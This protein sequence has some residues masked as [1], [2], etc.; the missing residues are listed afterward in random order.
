MSGSSPHGHEAGA[1][2]LHALSPS[3]Q[4]LFRTYSFGPTKQA[5]SLCIH[6]AFESHAAL[7]PDSLAIVASEVSGALESV[8]YSELDRR[9]NVLAHHLRD[10]HDVVPGRRVCFV[11]ERSVDMIVGIL[12]I[13]KS[14]AAYTLLDGNVVD[15]STLDRVLRD[16]DVTL[17]A[18]KFL[19]RASKTTSRSICLEDVLN[20][21]ENSK[22]TKPVDYSKPEDVAY[23]LY[24]SSGQVAHNGLS[25]SHRNVTNAVCLAPG[26][27]E[28]APGR[29]VSQIMDI[30]TSLAAW[31]IFGSLANGCTLFLESR[32]SNDG[33]TA[34]KKAEIV[35]AT[36]SMLA[37]YESAAYPNVK[38]VAVVSDRCPQGLADKW[39]ANGVHLYVG[40][41]LTDIAIINT[42]TSE[43]H[44]PGRVL[45]IG[46]PL[47]NNS[48]YVLQSSAD[49]PQPLALDGSG[50][51]WVGGMGLTKSSI[52]IDD[53][54]YKLDPFLADGSYMVSTGK[55]GRWH[56]DGTLECLGSET[57]TAVGEAGDGDL[58][59][60][61][62]ELLAK[63]STNTLFQ[64][65]DQQHF[66][67]PLTV[68]YGTSEKT[69]AGLSSSAS[70]STIEKGHEVFWAGYEDDGIPDKSQGKFM[71]NLRHQVFSL[72]RRL[73]GIVF[74]VNMAIL[75]ATF[76]QG[77]P[78]AM[79]LGQ[80]VIGNI[81]CSV[82][83]RQEHVINAFFA[84]FTAVPPSWPMAIRRVCAR[85]YGIGG[86]HSGAAVSGTVWLIAFAVQATRELASGGPT[87]VATLVV[88][89]CI[90]LLL[91]SIIC[92]AYPAFRIAK[93][94][95]FERTHRF[96][97]WTVTALVW[98][99]VILLTNDYKSPGTSLGSALVASAPFWLV[100]V[101]T[102]SIIYPW[103]HLRKVPVRAEI[104]SSHAVRL[105]FDYVTPNPGTF[106]RVSDNPLFEW[107]GF[108]TIA[109]P[110]QKGYSM[111]VSR[112]GDWTS[113]QIGDPPKELWVRGIPTCGVMSI[114]PIFRRVVLVATGS[115]IGPIT[116]WI[117]QSRHPVKLLW[118]APDVRKT[119]G[120]KLVDSL[121]TACPDTVIYDTRKHGKPDM[122][123]L[124]Y[125]LV[126]E[127]DAE[128]VIIISNQKLTV[129]VVYGMMS[130]GIPAFGAIWDS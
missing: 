28:M 109:Q 124:T 2:P 130:R 12:G 110:G 43:Y 46:K 25:V 81:F 57:T 15:Y 113:K 125:R 33:S 17:S 70:S 27:I 72:Y 3:D 93:H 101:L 114:V 60:M 127:Y 92:C 129:K 63:D 123:K 121:L 29:S 69:T 80:I 76:V 19:P 61:G 6:H 78:N 9:A 118:T 98:A 104:L 64:T 52:N 67:L 95:N 84:V 55:L 83:M 79:R 102:C 26:N 100:V 49:G 37:A 41:G 86:I 87:S 96:F 56:P 107:H 23:I 40:C 35:I 66:N 75:I 112:A 8:T 4:L 85:V 36:P 44:I 116:P 59:T 31:E 126:R 50:V 39:A 48:V 90:L 62:R 68:G 13:L 115:G 106:T 34:M 73:F 99:Q 74:I 20:V 32:D 5:P 18:R 51:I 16:C 24:N 122:V 82:L 65:P 54:K 30:S 21:N 14:G 53:E 10:V 58:A 105:Y 7:H 120:D 42:M 88:T 91:I 103:L 89:Y 11:A 1:H 128:A 45:S 38:V 71:R 111:V 77:E 97:G 94:N 119:F 22:Y 47:P 117:L 108:A